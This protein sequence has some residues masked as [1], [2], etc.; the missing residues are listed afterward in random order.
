MRMS[1]LVRRSGVPL[2]TIKFYLREGLLMPG[3]S[4]SITQADYGEEHLR[5]LGLIRALVEVAGLPLQKAGV[6]IGLIEHPDA[7]L[8]DA[9]GD[10]IGALPPY[11]E[12]DPVANYPR[13][14]A[15]LSRLGQIWEPDFTAV[16]QLERALEAA[17]AA[18]LPMSDERLAVYGRLIRE[19]AEYEVGNMPR[20]S[21]GAAVEY[22]VL[23]TA[24]YEPVIT[25]LRRLAHQHLVH[26][27][28]SEQ[29][30]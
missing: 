19:L 1:E 6:V 14:H 13:A 28:L 20:A 2:A 27:A 15:A 22:A 17:E 3:R 25:A 18:G 9:L 21:T 26:A 16:V 8:Y 23:G 7:G 24:L 29:E 10:A 11:L 5:R 12:P 30:A 4:T